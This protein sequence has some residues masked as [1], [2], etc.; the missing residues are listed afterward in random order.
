M[1]GLQR[2]DP[3][4][5]RRARSRGQSAREARG[6]GRWWGRVFRSTGR[7]RGCRA[8]GTCCEL[9]GGNLRATPRDLQ[10]W[11]GEGR[12]ELLVR[13]GER[14]RLWKDPDTG[15]FLEECP[16]LIATGPDTAEC[17][18]H[19]T[20]PAMCRD[21]PTLAHGRQCVRGIVAS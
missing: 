10:R 14:G 9:F 13:V 6:I 3:T 16:F 18:I 19:E 21:Y 15:S 12:L 4:E 17:W 2:T 8:C 7:S 5:T 20:K 11:Q 1:F